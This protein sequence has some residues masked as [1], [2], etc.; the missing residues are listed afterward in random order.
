MSEVLDTLLEIMKTNFEG[1][2][3]E[4][5]LMK[6]ESI[7][8]LCVCIDEMISDVSKILAAIC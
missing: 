1:K 4:E 7:G 2:V 6:T 8:K 3:S 5:Q